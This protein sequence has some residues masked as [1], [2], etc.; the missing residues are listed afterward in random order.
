MKS[1]PRP[2]ENRITCVVEERGARS[3]V[4]G[5]QRPGE[6]NCIKNSYQSILTSYESEKYLPVSS[7]PLTALPSLPSLHHLKHG[8]QLLQSKS[9][10]KQPVLPSSTPSRSPRLHCCVQLSRARLLSTSTTSMCA[11]CTSCHIRLTSRRITMAPTGL[12]KTI[13]TAALLA[14]RTCK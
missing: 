12:Q 4:E 7:L 10:R 2:A 6:G 14:P 3:E 13:P 11:F 1:Y 9:G 5:L 8:R